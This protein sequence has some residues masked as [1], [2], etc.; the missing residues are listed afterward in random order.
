MR[1]GVLPPYRSGVAADPDWMTAFATHAEAVGF[2]SIYVVE[3]VVV[4]VHY[5]QRYPYSE[6]GR[7]PLPTD[8]PIPDPL[9]L[10]AFLAARTQRITLATGV[11]VGPHHH[12][13]VLAK[14][15][16]TLDRLSAGRVIAGV[17]VGWMREELEATGV[18]FGSRGRRLDE[19]MA[20][21]RALWAAGGD[22]DGASFHGEFFSFEGVRSEPRPTRSSGVPLH[23]GGHSEAA[24]RRCGRFGDGLH[25]LGLDD[26]LLAQRWTSARAEAAAAGRDPDLLELSITVG[27]DAVD[28]ALV[29][30]ARA[31]GVHR[32]VCSTAQA[33]LQRVLDRLSSVAEDQGLSRA[34]ALGGDAA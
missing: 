27:I 32:I 9:E 5:E 19:S 15:L 6:S 26:E 21:M 34:A 10:L 14:R 28:T 23:V 16:A 31:L 24:A 18:D 25:P 17:G 7:M 29:E 2:E 3:H 22:S 12:P 4:P 20:A 13:L 33:E 1:F 11:M 30:R 8:C